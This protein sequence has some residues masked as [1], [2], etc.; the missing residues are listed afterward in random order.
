MNHTIHITTAAER[1]ISKTLDY[2]EFIIKN[3]KTADD[4]LNELKYK[5]NTLSSFPEQ[6]PIVKDSLLASWGIHFIQ[7]KN[8]LAFYVISK[9]THQ[10]TLIRFLYKKSNWISILKQSF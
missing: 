9:E 6:L 10:V 7:I 3:P 5:I 4:L 1:D 8:Y 2:I